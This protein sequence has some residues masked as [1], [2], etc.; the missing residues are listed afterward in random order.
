MER[1][2]NGSQ[3]RAAGRACAHHKHLR[4]GGPYHTRM[5]HSTVQ[6]ESGCACGD[7]ANRSLSS[8]GHPALSPNHIFGGRIDP[9]G[10]AWVVVVVALYLAI[11]LFKGEA[12]VKSLP[13][14]ATL[15]LGLLLAL[16]CGVRLVT[17]RVRPMPY[18]LKSARIA[19]L[20]RACRS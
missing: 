14:D 10:E 8:S 11:G 12:V 3:S 13:V 15:A 1:G 4:H 9:A 20:D 16:V 6:Y 18:V 2:P 17:G 7:G 19:R 5:R